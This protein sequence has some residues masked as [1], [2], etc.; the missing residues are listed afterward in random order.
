[1]EKALK[2]LQSKDFIGTFSEL[3]GLEITS[4]ENNVATAKLVIDKRHLRPGNIMNG[5]VSLMLIETVGS[6]SSF[7]NIDITKKNAFGLQV[8]ANHISMGL[9]GDTLVAKASKVHLG[10][11]THIWDVTIVNQNDRLVSSGRIT[12]MVTDLKKV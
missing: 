8:N 10:K 1:M 6:I 12:M 9:P 11:T 7:L 3:M 2:N 4:I 5:G